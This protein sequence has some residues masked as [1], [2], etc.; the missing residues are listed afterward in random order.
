M[1]RE[2]EEVRRGWREGCG[3]GFDWWMGGDY[4]I[5]K[6]SEEETRGNWIGGR[7]RL[8]RALLETWWRMEME[9]VLGI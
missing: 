5:P 6:N 2:E 7:S 9:P 8:F 3:E 1:W 4:R